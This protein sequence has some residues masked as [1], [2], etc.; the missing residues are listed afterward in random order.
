M[1]EA[2]VEAGRRAHPPLVRA[3]GRWSLTA[4]IVNGV[5][6]SAI[7]GMPAQI[8][9]LTG[10]W[11]PLAYLLAGLGI[12]TIVLCFAEV[13]SR[14]DEPGGPYLYAREGF[15]RFVGFQAGWL[16]FW[17]RVTALAANLNIFVQ[18]LSAVA[19]VVAQPL[20]RALTMTALVALITA[21]NVRGVR[22][23]TWTVNLFTV[24]KLLPIALLILVGLPA[25]SGASLASQAVPAPDWTQAILLLIFAYGGF[26]TPLIPA[27]EARDPR[28]DTAFA[29]LV[30]LALIAAAYMLVQLV[31]IGVVPRVAGDPAP[32]ATA[33]GVL[34]G[35]WGVTLASLTAVVSI[36]GY[37]TGT[38]LQSPRVLFSMA[39]RGELPAPLARVHPR[40]RTPDVSIVAYAALSLALGLYGS[41]TWNATLSAVVRLITYGLT[42]LALIVFRRRWPE[43]PAGFAAPAGLLVALLGAGFCAWLLTT[44]SF[45]QIWVLLALVGV[46][47]ALWL[48]AGRGLTGRAAGRE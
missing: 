12:L 15:G 35:P 45:A 30:A 7:F 27:G 36:Y 23:A 46:G 20:A 32:V 14:F 4:A 33:M 16:T 8:A 21:N 42:C 26:E 1:A 28:R 34:L 6:G 5:I 25:V 38:V 2:S 43:R 37:S 10:A 24:A 3:I 44:R 11:S 19:P 22:E 48:A 39:E 40:F 47:A 18:Y 9:E 17:I 13:G 41:F 31:V 29:L